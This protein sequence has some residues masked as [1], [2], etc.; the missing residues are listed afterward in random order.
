M[1]KAQRKKGGAD[2]GCLVGRG[3]R[4][5][6]GSGVTGAVQAIKANAELQTCLFFVNSSVAKNNLPGHCPT[7]CSNIK[8]ILV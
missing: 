3:W 7:A 8:G 2:G 5:G 6:W 4:R 1:F